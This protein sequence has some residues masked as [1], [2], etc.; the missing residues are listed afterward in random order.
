MSK[1]AD[2]LSRAGRN[3]GNW[4]ELLEEMRE[5]YWASAEL[6]DEEKRF[7]DELEHLPEEEWEPITCPG[8]PVSETVIEE[9]GAR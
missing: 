9:R 2:E 5:E 4:A 6:T 8:H 3:T 1:K 7:L